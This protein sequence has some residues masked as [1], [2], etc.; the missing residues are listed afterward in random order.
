[1]EIR[2]RMLD[3]GYIQLGGSPMMVGKPIH[4]ISSCGGRCLLRF[5]KTYICH[6]KVSIGGID[7]M[8]FEEGAQAEYRRQLLAFSLFMP[9]FAELQTCISAITTCTHTVVIET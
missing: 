2:Y 8:L 5:A 9:R 1:M 4:E 3:V 7:D 6:G